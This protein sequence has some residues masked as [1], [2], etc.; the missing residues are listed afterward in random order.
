MTTDRARLGAITVSSEF[1][2]DIGDSSLLTT[3]LLRTNSPS[4]FRV[5]PG[6]VGRAKL[7]LAISGFEGKLDNA[8]GGGG[9]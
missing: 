2:L 6:I 1:C 8:G 9:G 7:D 3:E 5:Q 4:E